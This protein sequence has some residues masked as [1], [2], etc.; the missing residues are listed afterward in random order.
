MDL[1]IGRA[2]LGLSNSVFLHSWVRLRYAPHVFLL[3]P[4]ATLQQV[5]GRCYLYDKHTTVKNTRPFCLELAHCHSAPFPLAKASHMSQSHISREG[6]LPLL[7]LVGGS[8]K[9][10]GKGH[11][12]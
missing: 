6:E 2:W 7:S 5:Q 11:E 12:L 10:Y 4:R 3:Y 1:Q 8:V 9:S